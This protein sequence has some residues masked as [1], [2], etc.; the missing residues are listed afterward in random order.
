MIANIKNDFVMPILVLS[1]LCLFVS[2]L[3][4][5]GNR[6]TQPVIENAAMLRE[7]TARRDII[8]QA[9]G[10]TPFD[11]N[12]INDVLPKTITGVYTTT[13]NTGY[14]FMVTTTGYGGEIKLICGIDTNGRIIKMAV[15]EHTETVGLGTPVFEEKHAGQ[16][17]GRDRTDIE[18]IEAI[19]GAT[20]TS[21]AYKNSARDAL[22]AYGI[23]TSSSGGRR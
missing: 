3:L 11:I 18:G 13:N 9:E 21:T 19:S 12:G 1:L 14:I 10:F 17:R 16:F 2:G 8:P 4:A 6:L 23:I 5:V 22:T 20:I 7:E 15:L